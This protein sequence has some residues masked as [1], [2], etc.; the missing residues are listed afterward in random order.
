MARYKP[1]STFYYSHHLVRQRD[2]TKLRAG[3]RQKKRRVSRRPNRGYQNLHK[4]FNVDE[5]L[6]DI[7]GR[8]VTTRPLAV[9]LVWNYIKRHNLQKPGHGRIILP[10][11]RLGALTG[12]P[13][14]EFDGF[15]LM[16]HIT[17]HIV[18]PRP[19]Q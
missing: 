4:A 19:R 12:E 18:P 7:I 6:R 15:K 5:V 14:V 8:N 3:R 2:G 11:Q 16:T 10:D 9:R 17:R 1:K 13:G